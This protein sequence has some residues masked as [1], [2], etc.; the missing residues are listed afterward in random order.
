MAKPPGGARIPSEQAWEP[1][2]PPGGAPPVCPPRTQ[3]Q[4]P[5][6]VQLRGAERRG[7]SDG[8]FI[9]NLQG[10]FSLHPAPAGR[11]GETQIN[12]PAGKKLPLEN[13]IPVGFL[14]DP[15]PPWS[16]SPWAAAPQLDAPAHPGYPTASPKP[17]QI[18]I[19][20]A[21]IPPRG[22]QIH[23]PGAEI[24]GTPTTPASHH[25]PC[26]PSAGPSSV[27]AP[28]P[29]RREGTNPS[30]PPRAR[31]VGTS[32]N[33]GQACRSTRPIAHMPL[34]YSYPRRAVTP[35]DPRERGQSRDSGSR[36]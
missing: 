30:A 22:A 15:P 26:H 18:L 2:I 16:K 31:P 25:S 21:E 27:P 19:Q 11:E 6:R 28:P 1:H 4:G 9:A 14:Q 36:P 24:P 34:L 33:F 5:V 12:H 20:G 7:A 10:P 29:T 35:G 8:G 32:Q 23:S 3:P 17:P 13:K